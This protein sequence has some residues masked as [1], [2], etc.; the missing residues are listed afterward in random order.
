MISNWINYVITL[1][2]VCVFP[3]SSDFLRCTEWSGQRARV[4]FLFTRWWEVNTETYV[5]FLRYIRSMQ[6]RKIFDRY[7]QFELQAWISKWFKC[8]ISRNSFS[9]YAWI[10]LTL[11]HVLELTHRS[12]KTSCTVTFTIKPLIQQLLH[13]VEPLL[14]LISKIISRYFTAAQSKYIPCL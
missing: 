12:S 4:Y 11:S 13:K 5:E 1:S 3:F 14:T 7:K 8:I 10:Y 2:I 9:K 6:W